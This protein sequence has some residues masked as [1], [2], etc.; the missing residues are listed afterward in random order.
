[1]DRQWAS[2]LLKFL[3]LKIPAA[4]RQAFSAAARVSWV[5]ASEGGEVE[6]EDGVGSDRCTSGVGTPRR[7]GLQNDCA[8]LE[9]L[10]PRP[11]ASASSRMPRSKSWAEGGSS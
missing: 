9:G 6:D 7:E 10:P 4:V 3:D 1:M 11:S 8:P 2:K 5:I